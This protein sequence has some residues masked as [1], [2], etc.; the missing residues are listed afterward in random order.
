MSDDYERN[1]LE[2]IGRNELEI[3][4]K[5][6]VIIYG[7]LDT[8]IIDGS[9]VWLMS[10]CEAFTQTDVSVHLL[11]KSDISREIFVKPLIDTLDIKII[12]PKHFGIQDG[13]IS[14]EDA[15]NL[16][17]ILMGYTVDTSQ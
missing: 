1:Y 8:N 7:D 13:K 9:S 4:H 15:I 17:E 3:D 16:I 14:A 12:E 10:L 11:L 5:P 2:L 6:S